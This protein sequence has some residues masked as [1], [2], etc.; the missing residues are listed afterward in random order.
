MSIAGAPRLL[1]LVTGAA[2]SGTSTAAGTLHHLGL[3]V[4]GPFMAAV[5]ANALTT[6]ITW[7]V[8][9]AAIAFSVWLPGD[10]RASGTR[11][12]GGPAGPIIA[13]SSTAATT[14]AIDAR[15]Q[16]SPRQVRLW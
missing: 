1:V 9:L 7:D 10:A 6:G 8:Y 3:D 4:P 11:H 2:R 16:A 12:A 13:P 15:N 14:I 5:G